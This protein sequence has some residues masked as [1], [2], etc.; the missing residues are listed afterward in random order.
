MSRRCT[1]CDHPK[2]REIDKTLVT[3][4]SI[5]HTAA[6]FGLS[7][8]ALF[9][10]QKEHLRPLLEKEAP[11][12]EIDDDTAQLRAQQRSAEAED[13]AHALDMR[14]QLKVVNAAC[15]E[16]LRKARTDAKQTTLLQAVDRIHRQITL[17]AQ[18]LGGPNDDTS[19][20]DSIQAQWPRIRQ[21]VIDALR[22]FPEA[23]I[24]VAE[25]LSHLSDDESVHAEP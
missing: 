17:Q 10:H 4:N 25:A 21:V 12:E 9:R 13:K 1:V 14:Q 11:E 24:A 22:P 2:R 5:R 16:V 15:L 3:G 6:V 19:E 8:S 18:L 23:R 7:V 20:A